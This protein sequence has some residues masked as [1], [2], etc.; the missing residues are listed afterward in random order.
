MDGKKSKEFV[1]DCIVSLHRSNI[2]FL[3]GVCRKNGKRGLNL[4]DNGNNDL[5]DIDFEELEQS[6]KQAS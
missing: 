1:Q 3:T 4:A 5:Q 2:K 6:A